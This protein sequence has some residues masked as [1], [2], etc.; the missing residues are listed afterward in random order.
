[1]L[2]I[3][4]VAVIQILYRYCECLRKLPSSLNIIKDK[5]NQYWYKYE[6]QQWVYWLILGS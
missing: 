2:G 4:Y 6:N 5:Y 3:G 1:M